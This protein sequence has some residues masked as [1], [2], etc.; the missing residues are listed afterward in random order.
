M[1]ARHMTREQK[2]MARRL[3]SKGLTLKAIAR[4]LSCSLPLVTASVCV[5]QPE[6]GLPDRW[7][8]APGR[9]SAEDREEIL[10]GL[11]RGASMSAIARRLGRAPSTITR[12]VAA[13][14]G[15]RRYG[16]WKAHCRAE[17]SARRPKPAKLAHPPL[18]RQV[19]TWLEK[20][21]SPQEIAERL[22]L[23]YPHDPMM[24]VSHET[25]YQS[26]FVQGRG[27]LRRELARCLRSGRTTRR[28]Q[29]STE[30][31]GKIPDLVMIA[32]RPG[33]VADRAVPGHW[34]GDLIIGARGASAVGTL[35]ERSTRFVLLLHL[36]EDHGAAS[37]EEIGRAHV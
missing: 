9:L 25:I 27:E 35:V 11:A 16:A 24:Q 8:P 30:R 17:G 22:R 32:D 36:P 19:T 28:A 21:W 12:E 29:G 4:E 33:E 26:L 2:Q 15:T 31:R 6:A 7:T 37:V 1:G 13:N 20:L 5:Q 14:G 23:E 34:E 3:K 18:V 10:L